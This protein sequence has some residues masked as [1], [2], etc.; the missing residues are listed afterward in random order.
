MKLSALSAALEA[1]RKEGR[2]R[3][4]DD[5]L[6]RQL[7]AARFGADFLDA[8]SNDYLGLGSALAG[9]GEGDVSRETT[10]PCRGA[11]ASRLIFG[12]AL[13]HLEVEREV[14]AWLA[15]PAALLFS[16][17]YAANLGALSALLSPDDA[18][19]SDAL[20]HASLIDGMRLARAKPRVFAHLDL[21]ELERGLRQSGAAPARWVVVEAY[22]S[23]DGDGPDLIRLRELC[24]R[25]DAS[26]YVDEAHSVGT[27]GPG[28][29]GLCLKN[30]LQ[31]DVLVAT[32]GKAVGSHGACVLGS[33]DVRTWLWNRA[34]SFVFST[35]PTPVHARSLKHQVARVRAGHAARNGLEFL[36]ER[37]RRSLSQRGVPLV[38]G[39]FG[40][41]LSLLVGDEASALS[42][43]QR[44]KDSGVLA[45][46]IRPPSVPDGQSR[47]R[48][49]VRGTWT[50]DQADRLVEI[51]ARETLPP[52]AGL[53]GA[54]A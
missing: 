35:A 11:G 4:P 32:F 42:L 7:L 17:G 20:N 2:L 29:A 13:E 10:E 28:G 36:T 30:G 19:F 15:M 26:L 27:F 54:D 41:I 47:V 1:L 51:V 45:Q 53:E 8:A 46:A 38:A 52:R 40:P 9:P 50:E 5:D 39:S 18:V 44:L 16:S 21:E 22:Y 33:N 37:V 3:L 34:R 25:Y 14:A 43:A 23:M 12:T 48:L 24:D 49:I 31:A 6:E